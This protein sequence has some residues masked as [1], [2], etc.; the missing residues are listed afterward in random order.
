[1]SSQ[2]T[3]D[4]DWVLSSSSSTP[5]NQ[6]LRHKQGSISRGT[7]L[8]RIPEAAAEHDSPR[9]P[10][11]SVSN[12][13]TASLPL[14]RN[15]LPIQSTVRGGPSRH[16][17]RTV[18]DDHVRTLPRNFD[19]ITGRKVDTRSSRP[20]GSA[21]FPNPFAAGYRRDSETSTSQ[22]QRRAS[23]TYNATSSPQMLRQ[24]QM[25]DQHQ[26]SSQPM[27][28]ESA[29]RAF[30]D[31]GEIPPTPPL[32][33]GSRAPQFFGVSRKQVPEY[34]RSRDTEYA[35]RRESFPPSSW[36]SSDSTP[37]PTASSVA[38]AR[39]RNAKIEAELM[40]IQLIHPSAFTRPQQQQP[41][42]QNAQST[43]VM[44]APEATVS[45][46]KASAAPYAPI[47]PSLLSAPPI[48]SDSNDTAYSGETIALADGTQ[49]PTVRT[50]F[51]NMKRISLPKSSASAEAS[52]EM[53]RVPSVGGHVLGQTNVAILPRKDGTAR[54]IYSPTP[55]TLVAARKQ[56]TLLTVPSTH[57]A[58]E[59]DQGIPSPL[60]GSVPPPRAPQIPHT[61]KFRKS[62]PSI[63]SPAPSVPQH[64]EPVVAPETLASTQAKS[65]ETDVRTRERSQTIGYRNDP[66]RN[67]FGEV[68][69]ALLEEAN[70][71]LFIYQQ[72]QQ[73]QIAEVQPKRRSAQEEEN[74]ARGP[75]SEK[76]RSATTQTDA[77]V[78]RESTASQRSRRD[79]IGSATTAFDSPT[80]EEFPAS[81]RNSVAKRRS[82]IEGGGKSGPE[83]ADKR[84]IVAGGVVAPPSDVPEMQE[85]ATDDEETVE[86][87][88]TEFEPESKPVQQLVID[89]Y[90]SDADNAGQ[91]EFRFIPI[92]AVKAGKARRPQTRDTRVSFRSNP[93]HIERQHG[94]APAC[95]RCFR[96]GFDVAMNLQLGE[97]TAARKA[98]Q[99]FVAAGGLGALSIRNGDKLYADGSVHGA[100][101]T[102]EEAL[103]R[104]YVDKLGEVAFGESALSRP[105]TRGMYN[106]LLAEK[107]QKDMR[108]LMYTDHR[109]WSADDDALADGA[110][111][112]FDEKPKDDLLERKLSTRSK[113]ALDAKDRRLSQMTL[114]DGAHEVLLNN[115]AAANSGRRTMSLEDGE[116][117]IDPADFGSMFDDDEQHGVDGDSDGSGDSQ[118]IVVFADRWSSWAK[119]RH[120]LVYWVA[121]FALQALG[122]G[123]TNTVFAIIQD[124]Q[125]SETYALLLQVGTLAFNSSQGGGLLFA[126]AIVGFGRLRIALIALVA[127]GVACV[128]T[129]F[130]EA[131]LAILALI[132]VLGL[133]SG[134]LL[135]LALATVHD[136]FATQG[137]R[138]LGLLSLL[139]VFAAGQIA[140]PWISRLVLHLLSWPWTFWITLITAACC[141]L[142]IGLALGESNSFVVF[143]RE[144]MRLK[145]KGE[146]WTP[147]PQPETSLRHV[148]VEDLARPFR[149]LGSGWVLH[150]LAVVLTAFSAMFIYVFAGLQGVFTGS[151]GLSTTSAA[152]AIT[153]SCAVGVVLGVV[154][155]FSINGYIDTAKPGFA[156]ERLLVPSLLGAATFSFALYTLALASSFA[157]T[158]FLTA[159]GTLLATASVVLVAGSTMQYILESYSPSRKTKLRD[160]VARDEV[161]TPTLLQ[162]EDG[163]DDRYTSYSKPTDIHL[164][165]LTPPTARRDKRWLDEHAIA[166]L[167]VTVSLSFTV[168]AAMS[169]VAGFGYAKLSFAAFAM[170]FASTALVV[171]LLLVAVFLLGST[172]R[173]ASLEKIDRRQT[174]RTNAR[175]SS[176]RTRRIKARR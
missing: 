28:S 137:S 71:K 31:V 162:G 98:F 5:A 49:I 116:I 150:V 65:D 33:S 142:Y 171:T 89:T 16:H 141:I 170:I 46:I 133:A 118:S 122:S 54:A 13:N 149:I 102:V 115:I 86:S 167:T 39:E 160:V 143:R 25:Y 11:A 7:S 145:R 15:A 60:S 119:A 168:A 130:L 74:R 176:D 18:S 88:G 104:N 101:I 169:V 2:K 124:V 97:G 153:L 159:F 23:E 30:Q 109:P 173:L 37:T 121:I 61:L 44:M 114:H 108:N 59:L 90:T 27:Q 151:H 126:N 99:N 166:S 63:G 72:Q 45:A 156:T 110:E 52:T 154:A 19:P 84:N 26:S 127:V 152:L 155:L 21:D 83:F 175:L 129:G 147:E 43:S 36:S 107:Q 172:S 9:L 10:S 6:P 50:D 1:M 103:G 123:Y 56:A 69:P 82:S 78:R 35:R 87:D 14:A 70:R 113:G 80:R 81:V 135:F 93:S 4:R 163:G 8:Q 136:L 48:R 75:G 125:P 42:Q 12:T 34:S 57:V 157:T 66:R 91:A 132:S 3:G 85:P 17:T 40:P 24:A 73:Q 55:Q 164:N 140:G 131:P 106:E 62:E 79:S 146:G 139:F 51:Q 92:S 94:A 95:R 20:G 67:T 64:D 112:D 165:S 144:A 77:I 117:D 134:V 174:M 96:A 22:L 32:G 100:S 111:Q 58:G 47:K 148:F 138:L 76:D 105:V 120:M 53:Q 29:A 128:I 41:Q 161:S 68:Q 158:W 38:A